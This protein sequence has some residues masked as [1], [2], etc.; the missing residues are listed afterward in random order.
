MTW[1]LRLV[2]V[3]VVGLAA[4][5]GY[6]FAYRR[7]IA[8]TG[9]A[10]YF[11][12]QA[13]LLASGKGFIDPYSLFW[14]SK[15]VPGATHPPL[16]TLVLALASALGSTTFFAQL[17]W[18][19]AI[20]AASVAVVAIAAREVAGPRAGLIAAGITALYPIFWVDDGSLLAETLVVPLVALVVWAFYRMWHRPSLPGAALLGALCALCALTRSELVLLVVF[21]A[22]PAALVCRARSWRRRLAMGGLAL[23]GA[24]GMF[25]PWWA[26]TVPRFSHP[27]LLSDQL[28]VTLA[29]ANCDQ[30]YGGRLLGY[31]DDRCEVEILTPKAADA[32]VRDD[33]LRRDAVHYVE[34]HAGRVPVVMAARVGRALGVFRPGQEIDLEWSVLGRPRLP[35]TIGLC[36]Y[37]LLAV[38]GVAGAVVL[39]GRRIALLPFAVVLAEVIVMSAVI[40]GQTRYRTPLDVVLVILGSVALD[41]GIDLHSLRRHHLTR[42]RGER[43]AR[44]SRGA[45]AITTRGL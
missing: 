29:S 1:R 2:L 10:F 25:A 20:G 34:H 12:Y 30:T 26:Y 5:V 9:D 24:L 18:S 39:R 35:A 13:N 11:H 8:P 27:E 31:W 41:R 7:H 40:F 42:G 28:G 23:A 36:C 45:H 43:R 6:V 33:D 19:C 38:L 16:W 21:L 17:L 22:L 15:V 37:Y 32:S 14:A 4:R 44:G 3:V